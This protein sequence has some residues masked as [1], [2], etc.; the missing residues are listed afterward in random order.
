MSKHGFVVQFFWPL[1]KRWTPL[2][3]PL[4][5]QRVAE[6]YKLRVANYRKRAGLP[7]REYR[8]VEVIQEVAR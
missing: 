7:E 4:P 8:I 5:S 3:D 1:T 2:G 6:M